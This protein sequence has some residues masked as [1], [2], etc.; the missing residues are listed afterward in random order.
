MDQ[1]TLNIGLRDDATFDNFYPGS[2]L[3]V[4]QA[5][6]T[7]MALK[8]EPFVYVWGAVDSGKTHLLQ[9]V[10]QGASAQGYSAIY[11]PLSAYQQLSIQA[12]E[13]MEMLDLICIDDIASIVGQAQWE[14][15][16]FHLFNAC[17]SRG[18]YLLISASTAPTGLDLNLNDL[19]S[20]LSSGLC[21]ALEC[22]NDAQKMDA[23]SLRARKRGL[24]LDAALSHFLLSHCPRQMSELFTRLEILDKA[25][26][27]A[28][29][30]L[31]IPF[32]K[33][34]LGL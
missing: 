10:C 8:G 32:A 24:T 14:E 12:L 33:Q 15:A 34:V 11:L 17:R 4:Y 28:K 19:K 27:R 7:M 21:Y 2:N 16:L 3:E 20:R 23:L 25:S 18:T 22:L 6:Q 29:R 5:L 9:A 26:L 30:R 1:L 13:G 31:T